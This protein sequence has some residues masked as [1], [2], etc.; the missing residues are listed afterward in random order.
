MKK[1]ISSIL[2]VLMMVCT[3]APAGIPVYAAEDTKPPVLKSIK[4]LTPS[5]KVGEYIK[6]KITVDE[7]GTG[8]SN[9]MIQLNSGSGNS[10]NTK[11]LIE[12]HTWSTPVYSTSSNMISYTFKI[13][14]DENTINANWHV[15]YLE[16]TDKKGNWSR[17]C[18]SPDNNNMFND[19]NQAEVVK[20]STHCKTTG[21]SADGTPPVVNWVKFSTASIVKPGT[22]NLKVNITEPLGIS[23]YQ[24][25]FCN[26]RDGA[27]YVV[28][29]EV[30]PKEKGTFTKTYKIKFDEKKHN[31]EWVLAAVY[32]RDGNENEVDYFYDGIDGIHY[33]YLENYDDRSITIRNTK[34]TV[35]GAAGDETRPDI[36]AITV[37][38]E[39]SKVLKPGKLMFDL[40]I[41][42]ADS[43]VVSFS[44]EI[45]CISS[46]SLDINSRTSY[47]FYAS[48]YENKETWY[49]GNGRKITKKTYSS[50]LLTGRHT[51][52][53]PISSYIRNG[54]YSIH[55][56][57]MEDKAGNRYYDGEWENPKHSA[58]FT[59]EDEFDYDFEVGITNPSLLSKV[60]N[61]PEGKVGRILLDSNKSNNKVSKNVLDAIA[62]LDKKLVFY[63]SSYQWIMDGK[64]IDPTKTKKLDL[65]V[66]VSTVAAENLSS[67]QKAVC[68]IFSNNGKLP[69]KIQFR[70]KSSFVEEYE[71]DP[72][73]LY[74][75]YVNEEDG[76]SAG[77]ADDEDIDYLNDDYDSVSDPK[78][79]VVVDDG[80]AWCYVDI[81]HNS[82]YLVSGAKIGA[83]TMRNARVKGVK[84]SYTYS[85][86]AFKPKVTVRLANKKLKKGIDYKVTYKNNKRIGTAKIIIKGKGIK[87]KK[88]ITFKIVPKGTKVSKIAGIKKGFKVSWNKGTRQV[89]GYEIQYS[90]NKKFKGAKTVTVAK[91]TAT[92]KTIKNLK[93]N[94]KYYVRVRTYKKVKGKKYYSSWSKSRIVKTRK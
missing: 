89:S 71:D 50:P 69:G 74:L 19:V 37:N 77:I 23:Y 17:Y 12:D 93:V 68:L 44:V 25:E 76:N 35:Y 85:G 3:L 46:G 5:V 4:V 18:G 28:N 84:K 88:T 15:A 14:T 16:F 49:D 80:D 21:S 86:K 87:G 13:K 65:N 1:L 52:T 42:E 41:T 30:T 82:K 62:G 92:S 2:I 66:K 31:G 56:V 67:N 36:K 90:L 20:G 33:D 34:I 29:K 75:Y 83:L 27:Y 63:R 70:F 81:A 61:M 8:L 59:V 7:R 45:N 51:F 9:A 94:R 73:D 58:S 57:E 40:D 54:Q 39:N 79:N 11:M 38:G 64:Q 32:L 55:V 48:G 53:I 72:G 91:K 10:A 6:I 78:F 43:G 26:K 22:A 47:Y 60:Q 24:F